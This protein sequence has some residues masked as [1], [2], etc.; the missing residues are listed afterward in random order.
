[1]FLFVYWIFIVLIAGFLAAPENTIGENIV[2]LL[3]MKRAFNI[4]LAVMILGEL[5]VYCQ[6]FVLNRHY[7]AAEVVMA[8][9]LTNKRTMT[10]HIAIIVGALL[11]FTMH[12][13]HF[14]IHI[15]PGQYGDYLFMMA[16]VG[17][18]IIGEILGMK[19]G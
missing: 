18:R 12:V 11:W 2:V 10:M 15:N 1:M 14:F 5:L 16:F 13:E 3:F 8:N 7:T 9:T 19:K 17:I 4:S 6:Q